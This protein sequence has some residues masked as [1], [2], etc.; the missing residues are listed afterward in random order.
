VDTK[1][2]IAI[3]VACITFGLLAYEIS[4]HLVR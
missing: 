2:F 4:S 3:I 1:L